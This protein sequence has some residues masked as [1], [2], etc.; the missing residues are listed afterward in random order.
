M[1]QNSLIL[2]LKRIKFVY[3]YFYHSVT[4]YLIKNVKIKL[5]S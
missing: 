1:K 2:L 5:S 4:K 3:A